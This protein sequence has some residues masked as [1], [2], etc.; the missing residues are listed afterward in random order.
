MLGH[1][2]YTQVT[3]VLRSIP[4]NTPGADT[5]YMTG[6]FN[7]WKVNDPDYKLSRQLDGRLSIHFD[8]I[9]YPFEYKFTRGTWMKVETNEENEYLPNREY[10]TGNSETIYIDIINW[11]DLGGARPL[12]II[13]FYY[14]TNAFLV[15][16]LLLIIY[17]TKKADANKR[18]GFLVFNCFVLAVLTSAVV[19]HLGNIIWAAYIE[20]VYK[21]LF[22]FWSI[23]LLVF[24]RSFN[25]KH[26]S[27]QIVWLVIPG[28]FIILITI[29]QINNSSIVTFM[30]IQWMNMSVGNIGISALG[31]G[32][33]VFTQIRLG[34]EIKIIECLNRP[35]TH[36][37][38]RWMNRI[39]L[40]TFFLFILYIV[41]ILFHSSLV[42]RLSYELF[43]I[44]FSFSIM[45]E[46]YY[47][48]RY[49]EIV[50]E[51]PNPTTPI[52]KELIAKLEQCMTEQKVYTNPDL[53]ISDLSEMLN[54]KAHVLSRLLN[55]QHRKN[56]RD[57][58]NSHR[59]NA[60]IQLANSGHLDKMTFLGLAHEVGFNSKSTFN[61]AFK[62]YTGENPSTYFK[63]V[64]KKDT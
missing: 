26:S 20:M 50:F 13:A 33:F 32:L 42:L 62:K 40:V 14:F 55:E 38:I 37:F 30:S 31:I 2:S 58:I 15:L 60:F 11:Q 3:F 22:Y 48:W 23:V 28:I 46:M 57:Y 36:Q 49:P 35:I 44:P 8:S 24:T 27:S 53:S 61:L 29:L 43:L 45:L 63:N 19:F 47:L 39:Q 16:I 41:G 17:R 52:P 1:L 12:P 4:N 34:R 56:F 7:D 64:G 21:I 10:T 25:G 51:R 5:I 9:S 18:L 59:I 6:S 54:T